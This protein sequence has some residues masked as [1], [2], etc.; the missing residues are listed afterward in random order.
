MLAKKIVALFVLLGASAVL[1]DVDSS[2][3]HIEYA[4]VRDPSIFWN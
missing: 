3:E 2:C 1:A 4:G